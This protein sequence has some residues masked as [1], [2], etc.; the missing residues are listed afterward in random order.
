M[1]FFMTE[2]RVRNFDVSLAWYQTLLGS[3]DIELM[4]HDHF[5][6]LL[7]YGRNRLAIKMGVPNPGDC[8]LHFQV[9]DLEKEI[10]RLSDFGI[11]L[12]DGITTSH[13]GYRRVKITDPDGRTIVLFQNESIPYN[14]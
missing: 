13:E 7:K 8:L 6:A 10:Q 14:G 2:I 1:R 9:D 11:P 5:F 12:C 3:D 4:D